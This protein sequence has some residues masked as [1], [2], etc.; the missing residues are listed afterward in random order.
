MRGRQTK[1]SGSPTRY[2]DVG[3]LKL[4]TI[5]SGHLTQEQ[6]DSYQQYFRVEEISN[7][8]RTSQQQRKP[9]LS[10]L[11]SGRDE[12]SSN[13]KR[14]PSPPPKY[15]SNGQ[16]TN[17]RENR[18]KEAMESERHYL[19]DE[20]LKS[21]KNY[22]PPVEY[23]KPTKTTEKIY[24]PVKD[25]PEINF[26][27]MLLGPR[28]NTLRQLQEGSG[29]KLAIRG[30]GS[31][32]DGKS[33][34]DN[35]GGNSESSNALISATFSNPTLTTANDDLHVLITSDSQESIAKAIKLTNE[36]IEKAISSP[37]GQNDLKRGQLRELAILNGTLRETKQ[38]EPQPQQSGR[39]RGLDVSSI[40]CNICGKVGHFARDCLVRKERDNNN[41]PQVE[42]RNRPNLPNI[43]NI[44]SLPM[45]PWNA[46]GSQPTSTSSNSMLVGIS[47]SKPIQQS[48][49]VVKVPKAPSFVSSISSVS[50][51]A[52][53][54]AP[55]G[56]SPPPPPGV[57]IPPPP[58]V[59]QFH[60]HH[61]LYQNHRHH[62]LYQSRHLLQEV[63][64][65]LLLLLQ[66]IKFHHLP[67]L[68]HPS[69]HLHHNPDNYNIQ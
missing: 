54:G 44:P 41:E 55:S 38:Y 35:G 2:I 63:K 36:V 69:H 43:P 21:V 46:I 1:W 37:V 68:L 23:R 34:R 50:L 18:T 3:N 49:P 25:Y 67:P 61:Q 14:D 13:Y 15:D 45:A 28:G 7:L 17:T 48:P 60:L 33:E 20:S 39:P 47:A 62:H 6:I 58:L 9:L 10:L 22:M 40:V 32:K 64:F 4:N 12:V 42:K 29:A 59:C 16:R 26:V 27:G 56:I 24:I 11:P 65:H 8:L 19:V 31:V 52:P 66:V 51:Q 53:P 5:I 30:K 57:S